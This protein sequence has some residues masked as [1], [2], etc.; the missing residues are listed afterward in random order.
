MLKSPTPLT[1]LQF[2]SRTPKRL[3]AALAGQ[4]QLLRLV[5]KWGDYEDLSSVASMT[6]LPHLKLRGATAVSNVAAL[7]SLTTPAG[8]LC[9][10]DYRTWPR[11]LTSLRCR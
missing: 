4:P 6:G 9:S 1:S 8:C 10:G 7:A 3:F 11:P 2:T 5:V